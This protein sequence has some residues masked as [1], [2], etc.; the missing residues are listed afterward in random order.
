MARS[1]AVD[2]GTPRRHRSPRLF[3]DRRRLRIGLL[4]G[5]FNPAH[6]GHLHLSEVARRALKL[7]VIWWMVS[8]QNPLKSDN[9][10]A[11]LAKRLRGAID[12]TAGKAWIRVIAPEVEFGTNL[13]YATLL[14][15]KKRCPRHAFCWLMGA[16]NLAEFGSWQHREI[17][18]ST[19]PIAVID[20]PG[21]S[22][23]AINKGR[24]LIRRRQKPEKFAARAFDRAERPPIWCFIAGHRH[25]ASAT[26][27]RRTL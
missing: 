18:A 11:P 6:E 26:A 25:P 8:P 24:L 27:L 19:M 23:Q 16:D 3:H 20:R 13:T 14:M 5:S 21:Y 12:K 9:N 2:A 17:I 4:G 7:D 10:M 15:M 22:Y 1:V